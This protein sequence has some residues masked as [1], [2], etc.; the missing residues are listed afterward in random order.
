MLPEQIIG[1]ICQLEH[2]DTG[3]KYISKCFVQPDAYF[4]NIIQA[5]FTGR[6]GSIYDAI[7][8]YGFDKFRFDILYSGLEFPQKFE[9]LENYYIE[10]TKSID[11]GFNNNTNGKKNTSELPRGN[12]NGRLAVIAKNIASGE[13]L[14]FES[15]LAA[16][17]H[18]NGQTGKISRAARGLTKS[19]YGYTWSL[20]NG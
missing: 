13:I 16:A 6:K 14:I 19:A 15:L 8:A 2:I 7:R 18:V 20:K 5:S 17:Q 1:Y 3:M 11:N 10:L 12:S 9:E 4:R